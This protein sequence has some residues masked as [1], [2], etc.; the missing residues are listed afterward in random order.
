MTKRSVTIRGKR[1]R[2]KRTR[3]RIDVR[4]IFAVCVVTVLVAVAASFW[5][6]AGGN[7]EIKSTNVSIA[8]RINGFF[9]ARSAGEIVAERAKIFERNGVDIELRESGVGIDSIASVASGKEAFGVTDSISFL[10]ARLKGIPIIAFAAGLLESSVVFYSLEKSGIR[11]PKDFVGKRVGRRPG[12]DS[13][14][15][16]DALLKNAGLARSQILESAT[17]TD[18]DA[19]LNDRVDV[20]PGRVGQE[21]FLLHQRGVAYNVV[22]I[23]DYGI[24]IPDTVYF[25]TEKIASDRPSLVQRVLQGII[26]GW[27]MAYADTAASVPYIV[28][29]GKDLKPEQVQYELLA[30][31]DFVM[32]LSRRVGEFDEQQWNQLRAILTGARLM[33]GSIDLKPAINYNILKEAYRRPITFGN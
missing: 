27:A 9:G 31:R 24:H 29:A 15:L 32:P 26:A 2:R 7:G 28:A 30:Q 33:D 19:L 12:T 13:A 3:G 17:E 4:L 22:R 11:S 25:T 16:Y 1:R 23:S 18:I 5:K 21:G 6:F 14:I 20:I 8:L 10:N